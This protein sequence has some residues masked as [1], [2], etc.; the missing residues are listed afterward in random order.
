MV[1]F[2]LILHMLNDMMSDL[3]ATNRA[4]QS[5]TYQWAKLRFFPTPLIFFANLAEQHN[6]GKQAAATNSR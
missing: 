2:L 6:K 3:C 1:V 5:A 4:L